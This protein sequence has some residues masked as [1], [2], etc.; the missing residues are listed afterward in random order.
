MTDR[1]TAMSSRRHRMSLPLALVGVLGLWCWMEA[2]TA[3]S[4]ESTHLALVGQI[5]QMAADAARIES[6]A[7]APRVASERQRPNDELLAQVR[8]ALEAASIPLDRWIGND[9]S[10]AVRL[11]QS[12]YKRLSVRLSFQNVSLRQVV[13]FAYHLTDMDASLS[14]SD[15]RLSAPQSRDTETWDADLTLSYL[16]YS[17][18]QGT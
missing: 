17:P 9:P 14:V 3:Y 18:L 11:V 12:P 8:D 10:P 7:T 1:S 4:R 2:R 5:E 15:L 6:L 16:I 13:Q